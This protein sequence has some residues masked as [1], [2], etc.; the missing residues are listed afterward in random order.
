M[1]ATDV[2]GSLAGLTPW[3]ANWA[4]RRSNALT[5]PAIE[6]VLGAYGTDRRLERN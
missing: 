6:L 5:R 2:L 3:L 1:T 4:L